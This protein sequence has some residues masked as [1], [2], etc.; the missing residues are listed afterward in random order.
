M[1][2]LGSEKTL[3]I[4]MIQGIYTLHSCGPEAYG[5]KEN[6]QYNLLAVTGMFNNGWLYPIRAGS[7]ASKSRGICFVNSRASIQR[8]TVSSSLVEINSCCVVLA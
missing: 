8:Q 6:G 1:Q 4:W 5:E 7:Q 2:E 3:Q